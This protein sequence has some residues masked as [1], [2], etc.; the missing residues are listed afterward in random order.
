MLV[1]VNWRGRLTSSIWIYAPVLL[2]CLIAA[3]VLLWGLGKGSL[4]N[5]DEAIYAQVA[6]EMVRGG[7]WLNLY[8][9]GRAWFH[10]PPL[11]IWLTAA[12][13][14]LFE[15]NVFWTR[16]ASACAG[17]A[18]VVITY[19][20]GKLIY[21]KRVG[22]IAALILLA[23][24]QF[25]C[26]ARQGEMDVLLT[27]FLFVAVYGYLLF[28]RGD[29]KW[30]Y[31]VGSS[32]GL[33]LMT[34]GI[35]GAIAPAAILLEILFDRNFKAVMRTHHFWLGC[36][37]ALT[38]A[39]PWHVAM[40]VLHG[41]VFLNEYVGYHVI[42]RSLT[43]IEG[44]SG[45]Y[46][47]YLALLLEGFT[48]WAYLLPFALILVLK[49]NLGGQTQS[50]I[51]LLIAVL[52]F[53]IYT[54]AQT[55]LNHYLAP[56]YPA[57]ALLAAVLIVRAYERREPFMVAALMV[58]TVGAAIV[59]QWDVIWTFLGISTLVAVAA[60]ATKRISSRVALVIMTLFMLTVGFKT[61]RH[62]YGHPVSPVAKLALVARRDRV[63]EPLILFPGAEVN[64]QVALFY[65]DRPVRSA[66]DLG[67]LTS[68]TQSSTRE[69]I[70]TRERLWEVGKFYH[71][72]LLAEAEPLIY[73]EIQLKTSEAR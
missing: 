42:H 4:T 68:I 53:G 27:F 18:T 20:I 26:Y 15:V 52:V 51:L 21:S 31:L 41:N 40:F 67:E 24:Y 63:T 1:Q 9:E 32:C 62:F 50:R 14:R 29:P 65:S 3:F 35:A 7:D 16:A 59:A 60:V 56:I 69:L 49:E 34:K 70:L 46:L 44:N 25:V 38:I 23:N 43:A 11:F 28:R 37:L 66:A 19:L 5:S 12:F 58:G 71:L 72:R 55:K 61:L 45:S 10:K 39:V 17:V 8:Y 36:L 13:Y 54:L 57:L 30:C 6:K 33:A 47:Y 2:I 73:A 22:F 64:R 48:P